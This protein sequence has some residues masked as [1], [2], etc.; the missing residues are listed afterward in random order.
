MRPYFELLPWLL[1]IIAPALSMKLFTD[2]RKL[3]TLELLLSRPVTETEVV[4]GKFAG[5]MLFFVLLLTGT[6]I[7]PI[8]LMVFAKPDIGVIVA[9][10]IGAVLVGGLFLSIGLLASLLVTNAVGSFLLAVAVSFGLCLIG[11]NLV[12]LM[13]AWPVNIVATQLGIL[14]H[15]AT[16]ARGVVDI[17]DVVYFA[18]L[19]GLFLTAAVFKLSHLR[20]VEQPRS[21]RTLYVGFG[22]IAAIGVSLNVLLYFYPLRID[23]TR[24]RLFTL[25][26]GTK[27]TIKNLP[28]IVTITVYASR[29]LPG[30]MQTTLRAVQDVLSDFKRHSSN[31]KVVTKYPDSDLNASQEAR[32]A[33]IQEITFNTIGTSK[34]EAQNGF[35]GIALRYGD[36]VEVLPFVQDT[37]DLEYQ[38]TRRIR[39]MMSDKPVTIGLLNAET[40][41][42]SLVSQLLQLQYT[43]ESVTQDSLLTVNPQAV[44]VVDDG[45][46]ATNSGNLAQY[47]A[48]GGAVLLLTEGVTV[49]RESGTVEKRTPVFDQLLADYGIS[50]SGDLLYDVELNETLSF[51]QGGVQYLIPYPFWLHALPKEKTFAGTA[52]INSVVLSW[53]TRL[54]LTRK[55]GVTQ[56]HLLTT[57]NTA[58]IQKNN[59]TITPESLDLLPQPTGEEYPV[60][61]FAQKDSARLVVVADTELAQNEFL[62][63]SKENAAFIANTVDVLVADPDLAAIPVKAA[64]RS[65]F[66]FKRPTDPLVFQY[67]T[68]LIA[69]LG[70]MIGGGIWLSRRRRLTRRIYEN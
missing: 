54:N 18:T 30:A 41:S 6:I 47:L 48:K 10:Y 55:E 46:I 17:R 70:F 62:Q 16:S 7:A 59:Y 39:K 58:G 57:G 24:Q 5:A 68:I 44:V 61:V 2:E 43:V 42:Y 32:S 12:T 11:L 27:Q 45:G 38:L 33:G 66:S 8:M 1:I 60:A 35:L 50:Q 20:L 26:L 4:L 49:N 37:S 3:G 65:V 34:F 19:T 14:S 13:V 69:P 28:D 53:A 64:G 51:G 31:L 52:G 15:I 25:S 40:Q 22:L 67:G 21:R 23:L 29:T 9:Q 63:T 36:K 56:Q